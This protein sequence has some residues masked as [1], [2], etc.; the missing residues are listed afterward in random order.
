LKLA[1]IIFSDAEKLILMN[2]VMHPKV[3]E[4]F[5]HWQNEN[6]GNPYILHE[7][8]ILFESG[9]NRLMD[10][11]ILVTAPEPIRIE[12]I[13][14]RD[15]CSED[16]IRQRMKNQWPD[17]QKSLLADYIIVNDDKT[18]LIP[19]VIEIHKILIG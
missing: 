5:M 14:G 16:S 8:A 6:G 9:F 2:G 13:K 19:R 4:R 10:K 3:M 7:A 1:Q 17:E 12:R 18:P 15:K 11:T